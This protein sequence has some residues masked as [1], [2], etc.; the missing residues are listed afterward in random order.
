MNRHLVPIK[1]GIEGCAN[2]GM[3]QDCPPVN[4]LWLKG[5]DAQPMECGGTVQKNWVP[6]QEL[7]KHLPKDRVVLRHEPLCRGNVLGNPSVHK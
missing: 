3:Q 2:K 4:K 5:L 7:L 6:L 1:I